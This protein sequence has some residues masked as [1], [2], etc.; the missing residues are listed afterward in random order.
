MT[1]LGR[2]LVLSIALARI[3]PAAAEESRT[4]TSDDTFSV[5]DPWWSLQLE[6]RVAIGT[7]QTNMFSSTTGVNFGLGLDA[8]VNLDH[9][10]FLG[11]G[12]AVDFPVGSSIA[13]T[14]AAVDTAVS[15]IDTTIGL[16]LGYQPVALSWLTLGIIAELGF[17]VDSTTI[18]SGGSEAS[19]IGILGAV[20]GSAQLALFPHDAFEIGIRAGY[21]HLLGDRATLARADADDLHV[22]PGPYR[23]ADDL[24]IV[25]YEAL[26]F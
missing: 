4:W 26:H 14:L 3:A 10:W 2:I 18:R 17:V 25:L 9:H 7:L 1:R 11:A 24:T 22:P 23:A 12:L 8:I 15:N 6:E 16:R 21:R 20:G 19:G 13:E 5:T